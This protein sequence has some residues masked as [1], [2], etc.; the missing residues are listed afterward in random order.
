MTRIE[1]HRKV[2]DDLLARPDRPVLLLSG[3]RDSPAW[4]VYGIWR[5]T[6]ENFAGEC[7]LILD[8]ELLTSRERQDWFED[9][10]DRYALVV[11]SRVVRHGR[12]W[13]F[14][15]RFSS[16]VSWLS[17]VFREESD[18]SAER[19]LEEDV[20]PTTFGFPKERVH[21]DFEL[22]DC[23]NVAEFDRGLPS[24][25][26]SRVT[27][28]SV[29]A[30]YPM[31][32]CPPEVI[33]E[34]DFE[35]EVGL[36][37]VQQPGV[38]GESLP[39][40]DPAL[41]SY[42]LEILLCAD[43]FR[44]GERDSMARIALVVSSREPYPTLRLRLR[45]EA[46]DDLVEDRSI[47]ATFVV[48]GRPC[49]TASRRVRVLA[50]GGKPRHGGELR[51]VA[52]A[53][54]D[55]AILRAGRTPDLTI[56]I[57]DSNGRAPGE[58][59]WQLCSPHE[60]ELEPGSTDEQRSDIGQAPA[61]FAR[62]LAKS[63]SLKNGRALFD[64]LKGAGSR[65]AEKIPSWV[66]RS[67]RDVASRLDGPRPT[68]LIAS[69]EPYVPWE[70]AVF[71]R[72][73]VEAAGSPFLGAQVIL[74]RWIPGARNKPPVL[75]DRLSVDVRSIAVVACPHYD[76]VTGFQ[77]LEAAE[78]EARELAAG[79]INPR[80]VVD[81]LHGIV[82]DCLDGNPRADV[83]HFALHGTF[84]HPVHDTGLVLVAERREQPGK[85]KIEVLTPNQVRA[86]RLAHGPFVFLNACQVGAGEE[87][88]GDYGGLVSGFLYAGASAVIAPIWKID[89][90]IARDIALRFYGE[91]LDGERPAE[92][93]RRERAL[94]TGADGQ[95]GTYL[96][97]QFFGHPDFA[98]KSAAEGI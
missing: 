90:R 17:W 85:Y 71:E 30:A 54:V 95:S 84:E 13:P 39:L 37:A 18:D 64:E 16:E 52:L 75:P 86:K 45:A 58:L 11:G 21:L 78:E 76:K 46:G 66:E 74:G 6:R 77:R 19:E 56:R 96:A 47:I 33:V 25:E 27:S 43:R 2:L 23:A 41:G 35:L 93:L 65:I 8:Q 44:V 1:E 59:C 97:Y 22:F 63:V 28:P 73:I 62:G 88:L 67:L 7:V 26:E 83:I 51:T 12:V 36:T 92:H 98:M 10:T 69:D 14:D 79:G 29:W 70:L 91:V 42:Q 49:G 20:E 5:G 3:A 34:K 31:L 48:G 57:T 94:F 72:S 53:G 60:V 80:H 15:P 89:D 4:Q 9:E 55:E 40:P 61:E 24:P 82:L 68:V 81:G 32:E 50:T 87:I 38:D